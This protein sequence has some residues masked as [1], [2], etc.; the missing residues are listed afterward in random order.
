MP[1]FVM[2]SVFVVERRIFIAVLSGIMLCV[3]RLSVVA[4]C[5]IHTTLNLKNAEF[6][7]SFH[8]VISCGKNIC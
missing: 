3:A 1:S 2:L 4:P 8:A 6:T 5:L 7:K